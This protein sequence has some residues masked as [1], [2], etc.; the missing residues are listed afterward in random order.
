MIWIYVSKCWFISAPS[1]GMRRPLLLLVYT[2]QWCHDDTISR[3]SAISCIITNLLGCWAPCCV[4]LNLE[5]RGWVAA[6]HNGNSCWLTLPHLPAFKASVNPV[7]LLKPTYLQE[8]S[9]FWGFFHQFSYLSRNFEDCST[10]I[11]LTFKKHA[12]A[13]VQRFKS[14]VLTLGDIVF[15]Y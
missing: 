15:V 6:L 12:P 10:E 13:L 3:C 11:P 9:F 1:F 4:K 14:N 2:L 7:L 5:I 8:C